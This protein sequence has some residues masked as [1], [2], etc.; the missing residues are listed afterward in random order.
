MNQ[1]IL[2]YE[3]FVGNLRQQLYQII[4]Q[5]VEMEMHRVIKNNSRQLDSLVLY[6]GELTASPNFYMQ[7]YYQ[8]YRQGKDVSELAEEI[9]STWNGT[10]GAFFLESP[11]M[12]YDTCRNFVFY[13]LVNRE[14]NRELLEEIPFI[15]VFDLAV[16]FYYLVKSGDEGIQ[17][18]R[19][20]HN[21][22]KLWGADTTDLLEMA[23][24]NTPRLFPAIYKPLVDVIEGFGIPLPDVTWSTEEVQPYML[25]N[26]KG[27]NG[28]SVWLYP[29]QLEEIARIHEDNYYI[30]PSSIHELLIMPQGGE[31]SSRQESQLLE[32]VYRANRECV[33]KEEYLSDN[34]Y[35]YDRKKKAIKIISRG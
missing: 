30:L 9:Y 5:G 2:N 19:I 11:D 32:M 21:I 34:I 16:I 1:I 23:T 14:R 15:P 35:Y 33:D 4:P 24:Q 29:G 31:Y 10:T 7:E 17:S 26:E 12:S 27:I 28:A 22:M 6:S 18:I 13:R 25:S 20:N 3:E 8:R